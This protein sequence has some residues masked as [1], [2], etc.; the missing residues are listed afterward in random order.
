MELNL[1]PF[2]LALRY[3]FAISRHT[4]QSMRTI[5]VELNEGGMSGYGESTTNPYYNVTEEGL[6]NIFTAV[7]ERLREY[8][9]TLPEKLWEDLHPVLK[10]HPFALSAIDCA[11]YDLYYKMKGK[12]FRNQW[13]IN[14]QKFPLTS[15]TLG[16]GTPEEL[17]KKIRDLPWPLYKLK[18]A[19]QVDG[20]LLREIG[21]V[22]QA[23][24]R[25]DANC[26][27]SANQAAK[28]ASQLEE[29]GV[30]LI[31][32][33]FQADQYEASGT[34]RENMKV[35]LFADESC[36]GPGDLVKCMDHF[37]GINIKLAKCG[38]LTPAIRMIK[39]ARETG[40][41]IM[42]GCMTESTVGISAAAQLLPFVDYVDLDGPL[43]LAE[44]VALGLK[45][46]NGVVQTGNSNGL[47]FTYEGTK[48][49]T[50]LPVS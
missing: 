14:Y 41:Q 37:D 30:E 17:I 34:L 21:G 2:D 23:L 25:V 45:Y 29:E 16:I 35:P 38:G 3:P 26:A 44:D 49:A 47:G 43:L 7:G 6:R 46:A 40:L 1:Y 27:W 24:I 4:Y 20:Q 22:T 50:S 19:G 28:I 33:P 15:Y 31:E 13:G 48:F 11:A 36:Q 42:I 39:M 8:H 18:V 9:F 32:Q 12:P 10:D 5:I